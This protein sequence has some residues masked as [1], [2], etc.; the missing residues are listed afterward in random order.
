MVFKFVELKKSLFHVF[1]QYG[2]VLE[3]MANKTLKMR[4]QAFIVFEDVA[5]S[6]RALREMQ[7]FDFYKKPMVCQLFFHIFN[8]RKLHLQKLNQI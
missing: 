8:G 7:G 1:S 2:K 3:I 5:S 6:T 4:G